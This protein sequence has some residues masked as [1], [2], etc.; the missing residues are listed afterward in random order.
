[1]E[2]GGD[3]D[4]VK[5]REGNWSVKLNADDSINELRGTL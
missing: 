2:H 1:V 5:V 4:I 3:D